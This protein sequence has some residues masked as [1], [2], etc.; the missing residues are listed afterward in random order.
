MIFIVE[1]K[2]TVV[3]LSA[4][5]HTNRAYNKVNYTY[6]QVVVYYILEYVDV[7]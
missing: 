4:G 3:R 2:I 5:I 7:K 1:Y 6:V